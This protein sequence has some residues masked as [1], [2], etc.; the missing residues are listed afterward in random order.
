MK[1]FEEFANE[2]LEEIKEEEKTM[3]KYQ[4]MFYEQRFACNPTKLVCND[5]EK[6]LL[7]FIE[8]KDIEEAYYKGVELARKETKNLVRLNFCKLMEKK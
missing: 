5:G 6:V 7:F 8:A 3:N 1:N 2:I 4:V